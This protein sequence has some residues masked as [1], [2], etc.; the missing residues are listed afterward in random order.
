M[1]GSVEGTGSEGP[2][3]LTASNLGAGLFTV[4]TV[5]CNI[6]PSLAY[7]LAPGGKIDDQTETFLAIYL[8]TLPLSIALTAVVFIW[9][10]QMGSPRERLAGSC[11]ILL[12]SGFFGL[13]FGTSQLDEQLFS[14]LHGPPEVMLA[15]AAFYMLFSYAIYYGAALFAAA[16]AVSFTVGLWL[17][18]KVT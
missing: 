18:E 3:Q 9:L 16:V 5:A 13:T 6:V 17:H 2:G 15:G 11:V 8:K 7:K 12:I 1:V 10:K 4:I 14:R